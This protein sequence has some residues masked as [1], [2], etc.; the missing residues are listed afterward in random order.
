MQTHNQAPECI[1]VNK[2]FNDRLKS[3]CIYNPSTNQKHPA[4]LDPQNNVVIGFDENT[5]YFP[6]GGYS[7]IR[8]ILVGTTSGT[9]GLVIG[10][11]VFG[12]SCR[13]CHD[14]IYMLDGVTRLQ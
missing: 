5:P 6:V 8:Q 10:A 4:L 2:A 14:D 3:V 12:F 1:T 13:H 9:S 7:A 11:V